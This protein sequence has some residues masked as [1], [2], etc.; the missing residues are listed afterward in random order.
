MKGNRRRQWSFGKRWISLIIIAAMLASMFSGFAFAEET[1]AAADYE[2][3]EAEEPSTDAE[4]EPEADDEADEPS[5]EEPA[6]SEE[7]PAE[8]EPA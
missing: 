8:E 2:A 5:E 3:V 1:E 6:P 7:E 4:E